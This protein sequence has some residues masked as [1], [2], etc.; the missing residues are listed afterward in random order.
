MLVLI[1]AAAAEE[2]TLHLSA[3]GGPTFIPFEDGGL[4][5]PGPGWVDRGPSARMEVGLGPPTFQVFV[6]MQ[7]SVHNGMAW[8]DNADLFGGPSDL[9]GDLTLLQG[10]VGARRPFHFGRFRLVPHGEVAFAAVLSPIEQQSWEDEVVGDFGREPNHPL[11]MGVAVQVGLE[12]G[13]LTFGDAVT[14]FL[15]EDLGYVT[16]SG[17]GPTLGVR[18][19]LS[20]GI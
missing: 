8:Y 11:E 19:G 10:G 13:V 18:L 6:V 5:D 9:L 7:G 12:E 14:L 1:G 4:L 20:V 15:A 17:I 2:L 16:V 3:S